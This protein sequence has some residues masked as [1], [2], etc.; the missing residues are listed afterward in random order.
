MSNLRT[1]ISL[2]KREI[3]VANEP[4]EGR[5]TVLENPSSDVLTSA[6]GDFGPQRVS[7]L[8]LGHL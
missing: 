6:F 1:P 4:L 8:E 7:R 5:G 2:P 3:A